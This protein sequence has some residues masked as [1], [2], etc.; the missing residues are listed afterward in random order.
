MNHQ[1][2]HLLIHGAH[3]LGKH[4]DEKA[5]ARKCARCK[6]A[7]HGWTTKCCGVKLCEPCKN[8]W[9]KEGGK[10]C[11]ICGKICA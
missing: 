4:I 10:Q 7:D 11:V 5:K 8:D 3:A 9:L 6:T 2:W 1:L